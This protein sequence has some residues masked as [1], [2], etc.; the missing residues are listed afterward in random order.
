M[1]GIPNPVNVS[2]I[3]FSAL[4]VLLVRS[5]NGCSPLRNR[6]ITR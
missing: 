2:K 4:N 5:F 1:A 3:F 6:L